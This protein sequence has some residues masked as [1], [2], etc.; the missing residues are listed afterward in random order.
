MN[1]RTVVTMN[2]SMKA[3]FFKSLN[4]FIHDGIRLLGEFLG[5]VEFCW[6]L[7]KICISISGVAPYF[8]SISRLLLLSY[9]PQQKEKKQ[10]NLV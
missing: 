3:Y 9:A 7:H 8:S 4:N 2:E 6:F 5:K 1:G 10:K